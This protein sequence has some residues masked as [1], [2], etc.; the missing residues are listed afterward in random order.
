MRDCEVSKKKV[1]YINVSEL[2]VWTNGYRAKMMGKYIRETRCLQDR[3]AAIRAGGLYDM[4]GEGA[5]EEKG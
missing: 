4:S 5:E 3:I 1:I 2:V